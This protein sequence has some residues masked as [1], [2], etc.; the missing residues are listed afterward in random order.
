M[1]TASPFASN[2]PPPS[3]PAWRAVPLFPHSHPQQGFSTREQRRDG[4]VPMPSS[5][6][7]PQ[8]LGTTHSPRGWE[9]YVAQ[10]DKGNTA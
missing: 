10:G 5:T 3:I 7:C 1:H 2:P 4:D 8:M 9:D 6:L